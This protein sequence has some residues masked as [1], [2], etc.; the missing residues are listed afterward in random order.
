MHKTAVAVI[1][2]GAVAIAASFAVAQ[3][4]R[5][6]F[7]AG[8]K[9]FNNYLS[10]DRTGNDTEII[11]LFANDKAA[12]GPG[13]DG[14]FAD[15]S[16]L[17]GEIYKARLNDKGEAIESSLGRRVR[18]KLAAIAVMEKRS[19]WGGTIPEDLRTGDWDFAVFSPDG[20]RLD[21]DLNGCRSCHTPLKE[22]DFLFSY[23]HLK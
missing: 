3:D 1:A 22:T 8:Y 20:K 18:D 4:D 23:D 9:S 5:V 17:V 6:A 7:P 2:L 16:V 14:H 11:R 15:G 21:K 19:G 10:L 12:A 13:A